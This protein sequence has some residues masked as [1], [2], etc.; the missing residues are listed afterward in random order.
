MIKVISCWTYNLPFREASN[1]LWKHIKLAKVQ[2][3]VTS[4]EMY[5]HTTYILELVSAKWTIEKMWFSQSTVYSILWFADG[6][7]TQW[8]DPPDLHQL[9]CVAAHVPRGPTG[10]RPRRVLLTSRKGRVTCRCT[11]DR[12]LRHRP[13][14]A[15]ADIFYGCRT[16]DRGPHYGR[17]EH[18]M[19]PRSASASAAAASSRGFIALQCSCKPFWSSNTHPNDRRVARPLSRTP[20]VKPDQ[21]G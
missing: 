16:I 8:S 7:R 4:L 3:T 6:F 2:T 13:A 19:R 14:A 18:S 10:S 20:S 17:H 15:Q 1:Y 9:A 21:V 12:L 11:R 5:A